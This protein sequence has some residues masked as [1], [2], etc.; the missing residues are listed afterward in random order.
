M[1]AQVT[2]ADAAEKGGE[3]YMLIILLFLIIPAIL[4]FIL[5]SNNKEKVMDEFCRLECK[6]NIKSK[7]KFCC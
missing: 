1:I 5:D 7:Y 2:V 6:Q 4:L 3:F